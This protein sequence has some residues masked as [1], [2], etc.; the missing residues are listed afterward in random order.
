MDG[1]FLELLNALDSLKRSPSPP[2]IYTSC[3]HLCSLAFFNDRVISCVLDIFLCND[4]TS[5]NSLEM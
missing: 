3:F 1:L 4:D 5:P 2:C